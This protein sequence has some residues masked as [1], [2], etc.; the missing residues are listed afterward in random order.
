MYDDGIDDKEA[1]S[2]LKALRFWPTS[3]PSKDE[4][5]MAIME[6]ATDSDRSCQPEP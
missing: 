4:P 2:V 1:E 6:F 3:H 5:F